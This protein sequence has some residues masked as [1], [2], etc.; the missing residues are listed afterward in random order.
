ML[1]TL[2]ILLITAGQVIAYLLGWIFASSVYGWRWSMYPGLFLPDFFYSLSRGKRL[3]FHLCEKL[4]ST[5]K[6]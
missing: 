1:V 3:T 4:H 6:I 5:F 2:T